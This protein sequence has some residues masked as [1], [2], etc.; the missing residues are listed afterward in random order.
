M[1]FDRV[2]MRKFGPPIKREDRADFAFATVPAITQFV[3]D[4]RTLS[5][6]SFDI[7]G[8][9]RN[10]YQGRVLGKLGNVAEELFRRKPV[11]YGECSHDLRARIKMPAP[12][13]ISNLMQNIALIHDE[14]RIEKRAAFKC[15][16]PQRPLSKSMDRVNG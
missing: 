7:R 11:F 14:L 1:H 3:P 4:N 12:E 5:F 15:P 16:I 6:D 13:I 10:H 2:A 8:V 9:G